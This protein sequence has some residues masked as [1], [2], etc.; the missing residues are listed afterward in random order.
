MPH[1]GRVAAR[2]RAGIPSLALLLAVLVLGAPLAAPPPPAWSAPDDGYRPPVPGPVVAPFD[3]PAVPWGRGNRGVDLATRPGEAV[4]AAGG[5][6]VTFAGVVAG[7]RHVTVAHRDGLRTTYS[8]LAEVRV[9]AGQPV[10]AGQVVGTAGALLHW[11]VRDPDGTYLDPMSL[12]GRPAGAVLVPGGDDGAPPPSS[13]S[14]LAALAGVA[15]E[16]LARHGPT[17]LGLLG[18]VPGGGGPAALALAHELGRLHSAV[19]VADVAG[20]LLERWVADRP[21]TPGDV[22][23]PPPPP[24]GSRLVVLVGGFGSS[25]ASAAV[26]D[27]DLV[28]LGY[29]ADDVVRFSYRGGRTPTSAGA[30]PLAGLAAADYDAHDSQGDLWWAGRDLAELL[31]SMAAARPGV[32]IDVIA[33]SQGGVVARLALSDAALPPEVDAVVTLGTPHQGADLATAAVAVGGTPAGAE[34]LGVLAGLGLPFDPARP[35]LGQLAET[36]SVVDHLAAHPPPPGV[37]VTSVAARGD[38]T[39]PAPRTRV[40]GGPPPVVVDLVGPTAHDRLPGDPRTTRE[41]AL[42]VAGWPPTCRSPAAEVADE[43][44]GGAVSWGEDA[45]GAA[46]ATGTGGPG[47]P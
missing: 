7:A 24:G 19:Q 25:S 40:A 22:A 39:V 42:A 32:P 14:E 26:D 31:R 4:G 36:S 6:V 28:A 11:G 47:W 30:G 46:L 16:V 33:H 3:P 35:A 41:I 2:H 20:A 44:V 18:P 12:L 23:P 1:P 37:R 10:V 15:A 29:R 34:L 38:L 21:C 9:V 27:V 45:L 17:A 43:V 8:F 13:G 5:G